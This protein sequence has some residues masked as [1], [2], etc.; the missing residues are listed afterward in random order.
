MIINIA[1]CDDEQE[2]LNMIQKELYK[3]TEKL[4]IT[5][6]TYLYRDGEKLVDLIKNQKEDFDI[7]FLDIDMPNIS[8]LEIAKK[9][10]EEESDIILI[11]ISAHEQYVFES[12][13]YNPFRYIRKSRIDKELFLALKAACVQ[14]KERENNHIVVKAEESEVKI[15]HSDIM[16]FETTERKVGIHLNNGE[17]LAVRKTIKELC[18]ELNDEHFIRIH[19]GCVANAKYIDKFSSNDITLDSGEQL[20]VSRTRVKNIKTIL[21]NYWG[22]K[23]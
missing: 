3:A 4:N 11:F 20:L 21:L 8:G 22:D 16:Y 17:V 14:L 12:I 1:V 2:S 15:R 19:S 9:L 13:E 18:E 6:E 23:A 5:I 7:L 10:R